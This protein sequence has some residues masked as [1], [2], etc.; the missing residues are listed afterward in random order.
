MA[1]LWQKNITL[2]ALIES[3]TVGRDD[4]LDQQLLPADA[5][6]SMAQARQLA[7]IGVMTDA[8]ASELVE[9]VAPLIRK[10]LGA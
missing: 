10:F 1:K 7:K 4:Q 3:Y 8:E 5:L 2:D 9:R 6:A